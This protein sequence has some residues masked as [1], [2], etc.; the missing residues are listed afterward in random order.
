MTQQ[1]ILYGP[2]SLAYD[3]FAA[4]SPAPGAGDGIQAHR[5]RYPLGKQLVFD[6]GRKFRFALNGGATLVVGNVISTA[7]IVTTDQSMAAAATAA[8]ATSITFTHGAATTAINY[9]AEGYATVSLAPGAGHAYK[10]SSHAALTSGGADTVYLA[11][12][13]SVREALT[14]TSDISLVAHPYASVIQAAASLSGA[15]VGVAVTAPTSGRFCFLQ[16]R[17]LA[18]VLTEGT[19]VI[20]MSA[21]GDTATAGACGPA[22]AATEVVIGTVQMVEATTEWSGIFL[23]IDG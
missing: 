7:A 13:E 17:G 21:V 2:T 1:T 8:G 9:F 20:G 14:T 22:A 5:G 10:I 18:S 3:T 4:V 11:P 12:G 19:L 6:D 16:T 23:T 15:A